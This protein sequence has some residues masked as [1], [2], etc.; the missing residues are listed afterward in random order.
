[1]VGE[2]GRTPG[3]SGAGGR[4]HYLLLSSMLAGGGIKGGKVIGA[5][6]SDDSSVTDYGWDPTSGNPLAAAPAVRP[7][8]GPGVDYLLR[9]GH[10]L[11]HHPL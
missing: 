9:D 6:N 4:D 10:R 8:G 1:M 5:T 11:D 3:I 7:S 2:F